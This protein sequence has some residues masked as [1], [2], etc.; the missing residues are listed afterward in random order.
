MQDSNDKGFA[1]YDD[2][3]GV[4]HEDLANGRDLTDLFADLEGAPVELLDESKEFEKK[5]D[6]VDDL[7]DLDLSPGALDK[8][9]DS[10]RVYLREMGMVP[11]LTREGEIELAKRIERGE[12]AVQKAL[13]RSRLIMQLLLDARHNI[14]RGNVSILE[15]LQTPDPQ[16]GRD[17]DDAARM[18]K[19]QFF[20][21]TQEIEKLH[22]KAHQTQQK[23][24]SISRNMKPKQYRKFRYEYARLIICISRRIRSLPFA[25][26]PACQNAST[27]S[28]DGA[29]K[30][31][32]RPRVTGCSRSVSPMSKSS[33]STSSASA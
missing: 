26:R 33:H 9:N 8:S 31:T 20:E 32:C 22:R 27:A 7:S 24:I 18:A 29:R 14:E 30:P 16:V 23:L 10:V 1:L 17:E 13:S 3:S 4:A 5:E 12:N 21:A 11:L 25:P 2:V 15:V 6:D 28:W 19:E